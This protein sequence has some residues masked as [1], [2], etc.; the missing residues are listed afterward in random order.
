MGLFLTEQDFDRIEIVPQLDRT[1]D[2]TTWETLGSCELQVDMND[3]AGYWRWSLHEFSDL[4]PALR[5]VAA[6]T[7]VA[8]VNSL[9]VSGNDFTSRLFTYRGGPT[10]IFG[11]APTYGAFG[12]IASLPSHLDE[13]SGGSMQ[14]WDSAFVVLPE[15]DP[16]GFATG[17]GVP[18]DQVVLQR[19]SDALLGVDTALEAARAWLL[20][21]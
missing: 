4:E 17:V 6:T 13:L 5:G 19:Q 20:E 18:P 21:E 8:V 12:P 2:A 10:K 14:F 11:P 9:D 7:R 16:A 3:C 15:D 1:L